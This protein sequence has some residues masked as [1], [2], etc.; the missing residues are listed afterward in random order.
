M[1]GEH[2]FHLL[3][4]GLT[5]LEHSRQLRLKVAEREEYMLNILLNTN[6]RFLQIRKKELADAKKYINSKFWKCSFMVCGFITLT[7]KGD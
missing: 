7:A 3:R 5:T 2:L 6:M 1:N 4:L